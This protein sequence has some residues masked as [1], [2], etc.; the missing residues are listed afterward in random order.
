VWLQH[1]NYTQSANATLNSILGYMRHL[2]NWVWHG[3][4]RSMGDL[5]NNG[6]FFVNRGTERMLMHVRRGSGRREEGGRGRKGTRAT[7]THA[8][9]HFFPTP[10]PVAPHTHKQ[11]RSGLNNIPVLE[12]Y[13]FNPD[14]TFLLSLGMGALSGQLNNIDPSTGATSMGFHSVPFVLD[15]DPHSGDFGCGFFGLTLE[16]ASTITFDAGLGQWLCYLCNV[17]S[18]TGALAPT[19]VAYEVRDAYRART[20]L[21]PVGAYLVAEAGVLQSVL[22]DL[23]AKTA[24]V[25]FAP[26][27]AAPAAPAPH[28]SSPFSFLRLSV[29][30]TAPARPG[31]SFAVA[32]AQGNPLPVVRGAFQIP[33]AAS[34]ADTTTVVL[35][36]Q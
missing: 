11:Y 17:G 10:L 32:D 19:R 24:T 30:K 21:E 20:F 22:L 18:Q 8:H 13:R 28:A 35:S 6:K 12:G 29:T 3:G 27:T 2:P 36:W 23:A 33:P 9:L 16:S 7:A 34:D 4:A 25:V 26:A 14:D 15:F 5:G 31:S 1:Y